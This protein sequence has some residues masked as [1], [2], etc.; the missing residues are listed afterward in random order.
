MG[1]H[2]R[3]GGYFG[4]GRHALLENI[5]EAGF[6]MNFFALIYFKQSHIRSLERII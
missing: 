4:C 1:R 6:V 5:R 2:P 3:G